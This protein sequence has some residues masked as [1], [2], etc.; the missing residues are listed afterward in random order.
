VPAPRRRKRAASEQILVVDDNPVCWKIAE[1]ILLNDGYRVLVAE[2]GAQAIALA[3]DRRRRID[4]ILMD[5]DLP[6]MNGVQAVD[7]IRTAFGDDCP[8]V[9]LVTAYGQD[10]VLK[11][12]DFQPAGF[13]SK[14]V[15]SSSLSEVVERTL[16]RVRNDA[17]EFPAVAPGQGPE[18]V[19]PAPRLLLVE[20]NDINRF[21][22]QENLLAVGLTVDSAENG[23]EALQQ[24]DQCQYDLVLMDLQM[25]VMDGLECCR[26]IRTRFTAAQLPV[27]AMTANA[28]AS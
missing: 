20:D 6:D 19:G 7:H 16:R 24:L 14:P 11:E 15:N 17:R 1:K 23:S 9:V 27:I 10:D 28:Y 13:L 21:L 22:A 18:S 5:W 12:A 2:S 3:Q 4:L 25:P 8:P 26:Q